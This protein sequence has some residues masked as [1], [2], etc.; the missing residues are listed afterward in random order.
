MKKLM[1]LLFAV[2]AQAQTLT[3]V[4]WH[5]ADNGDVPS[6]GYATITLSSACISFGTYINVAPKIVN[7]VGGFFTVNLVPNDT[8]LIN[9]QP[10]KTYYK[11]TWIINGQP[12]LNGKGQPIQNWFVPT[13][14]TALDVSTVLT[15][16]VPLPTAPTPTIS[17]LQ[18]S[19]FGASIGQG[20]C[21]NGNNY[22]PGNCAGSPGPTGPTGPTTL[23]NA[24]TYNF[25]P[26]SPTGTL[27][28]GTCSFTMSPMP[29]GVV[30]G[31]TLYLTAGTGGTAEWIPIIGV[32]SS[33][34]T[35][36]C[37]Q[38]HGSGYQVES[39]AGGIPEA[40]WSVPLFGSEQAIVS[41]TIT[42]YGPV[43]FPPQRNLT[44]S[45]VG[46][47]FALINRSST[48]TSGDMFV[49]NGSNQW[50]V[51]IRDIAIEQGVFAQ[52]GNAIHAYQCGNGSISLFNVTVQNG[53]TGITDQACALLIN[54]AT[55]DMFPPSGPQP[56]AGLYIQSYNPSG[57]EM[58]GNIS[59]TD[60]NIEGVEGSAYEPLFCIYTTGSDGVVIN[61]LTAG[62]MTDLEVAP[63]SPTYVTNWRIAH[64]N[65]DGPQQ[66]VIQT[67][68][69]GT[70]SD[71][72]VAGGWW[73][74]PTVSGTAM[75]L[76]GSLINS[77]FSD[78]HIQLAVGA[79]VGIGADT[80]AQ[81]SLSNISCIGA[82]PSN[83][84]AT[85]GF[86]VYT[87]ASGVALNNIRIYNGTTG[88]T[89]FGIQIAGNLS[90]S[91]ING[92]SCNL[93]GDSTSD[94]CILY[95]PASTFTNV[96][97]DGVLDGNA[98]NNN[99][100]ASASS[101]NL[102][103]SILDS[104]VVTGTT[105]INTLVGGWAGRRVSL[106]FTNASPGGL[107]A[108]GNIYYAKTLTQNQIV[109]CLFDGTKWACV[110]P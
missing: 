81:I 68:G 98:A 100:I 110:G 26:Q 21:W 90:D 76:G 49:Q 104:Y 23:I 77:T 32:T 4:T 27:L 57:T 66:G 70:I 64:F 1:L 45:G 73:N 108:T 38:S 91:V 39:V 59:I 31:S 14:A 2:L 3:T 60:L 28:S 24:N 109:N 95:A 93:G 16:T 37:G 103:Q 94:S 52:T 6:V 88:H 83:V 62:C 42:S 13:S 72:N 12:L 18:L 82:N 101:V 22:A 20:L 75:S 65:T 41:N 53:Y 9:N 48:F 89:K 105:Q 46:S 86:L 54:H 78:L 102:G 69:T 7:L 15:S 33:L 92:V 50:G 67:Q 106:Q 36:T 85:P 79:C 87:G 25:T 58:T 107:G 19:Q 8:C 84:A 44:V 17:P 56:F 30:T 99:S 29:P 10:N 35:G 11:V 71:F 40:L 97:V 47:G 80:A 34:V 5:V 55:I 63:I 96:R 61:G 74:G 43:N 51:T